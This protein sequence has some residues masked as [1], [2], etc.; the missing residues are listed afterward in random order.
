VVISFLDYVVI[1]SGIISRLF[2]Y[3]KLSWAVILSY[4]ILTLLCMWGLELGLK[5]QPAIKSQNAQTPSVSNT[6]ARLIVFKQVDEG[7]T[8]DW[9]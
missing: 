9:C 4:G 7:S 2:V 5:A 6:T 3:S 8:N 1:I